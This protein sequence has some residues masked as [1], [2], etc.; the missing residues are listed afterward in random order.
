MQPGKIRIYRFFGEVFLW[1]IIC[2]IAWFLTARILNIPLVWLTDFVLS[3]LSNDTFT[4][5]YLHFSEG[6]FKLINQQLIIN[7]N[8]PPPGEQPVFAPTRPLL[9]G[10]GFAVF[11]A[12]TIATPK[13][14]SRKWKEIGVAYVVFLFVQL[15]G[16]SCEALMLLVYNSTPEISGHF[17]L[18]KNYLD[19]LGLSSQLATLVLPPVTP[20]A[21]WIMFNTEFMEKLVGKKLPV[22]T[23]KK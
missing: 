7:T 4:N 10:Y 8:I 5:A 23:K 16:V 11:S 12:L 15:F 3:W 21:L 13:P 18:I 6:E 19:V 22:K 14:E 20:L 1:L 9:Y 2:F 17:P